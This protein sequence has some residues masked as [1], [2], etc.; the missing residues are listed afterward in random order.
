MKTQHLCGWSDV[1]FV[2]HQVFS[3]LEE[4]EI[5]AEYEGGSSQNSKAFGACPGT[6]GWLPGL[7]SREVLVAWK[8]QEP[9]CGEETSAPGR[10]AH[11]AGGFR[12]HLCLTT[13]GLAAPDPHAG[14]VASKPLNNVLL[15]QQGKKKVTKRLWGR[16]L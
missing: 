1:P 3:E 15:T 14:C 8:Q 7:R 13:Q 10:P 9:G 2:Y 11:S 6:Q 4:G 5:C 16:Q 12:L